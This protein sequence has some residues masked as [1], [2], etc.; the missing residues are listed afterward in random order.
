[1][2]VLAV[3][4]C[5]SPAAPSATGGSTTVSN[6]A[7]ATPADIA[8]YQGADRQQVLEAGAHKEGTVNWYTVMAG[9]AVDAIANGFKQKYPYL[10]V[11]V[12]RADSTE[13]VTRADQEEQV[14]K[15]VF[16][17]LDMASPYVDQ[18]AQ[19]YTPY[20]SP[21]LANFTPELKFGANGPFVDSAS[22][23]TTILGFGYNTQLIPESAVPKTHADLLNPALS[24]K[25]ALSGTGTGGYWVGSVLKG[26]GDEKGRAFIQQFAKQQSPGVQQISAKALLDLVAKGEVPASPTI[27]RDHVRQAV[28]TQNAPVAWVALEP[29]TTLAT[30]MAYAAKAPDPN[31]GMLFIDYIMGT[32][33]QQVLKDHYYTTGGEPLPYQ[34]W[35]PGE[36]ESADQGAQDTQLWNTLFNSTFR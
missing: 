11:D 10:A 2:V 19:Q 24:G 30:K 28:E 12:Y 23:W 14:G 26:M 6:S 13:I 31:A 4:A 8:R 9:D 29:V 27:Y 1:M 21:S 5:T 32:D 35:L 3:A 16:D 36:G 33:G 25:L 7:P 22:D 34:L 20:Y 17:V 15:H 18:L